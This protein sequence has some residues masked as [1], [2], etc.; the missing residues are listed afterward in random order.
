[1]PRD[2]PVY[3]W[4]FTYFP[5]DEGESLKDWLQYQWSSGAWKWLVGQAECAPDTGRIHLQGAGQLGTRKRLSGMK[6]LDDRVHWEHMN[7]SLA[8][9]RTYCT[10]DDTRVDGPW[11][12]GLPPT[13]GT[14]TTLQ[15]VCKLVI[16]GKTEAEIAQE[17]PDMY[18]RHYKG[19]R[20]LHQAIKLG[21]QKRDWAPELWV[22]VGPTRTGKTSFVAHNWPDAYW[23]S[24]TMG[25][26][27]DGYDGQETVVLDDCLGDYMTLTDFKRLIDRYPM[28]VQVKGGSVPMLAKRIVITS[29][30]MPEHWYS[31]DAAGAVVARVVE[32][33]QGRAVYCDHTGWR[34]LGDY[35]PWSPPE[36]Y[37][38]P[39]F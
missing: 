6:K 15:D 37:S 32:F 31:N 38:M 33:A 30:V 9:A 24:K 21:V 18:V 26:W 39:S 36:G 22:L 17:A 25:P 19:I 14:G 4:C 7:G 11:E 5:K 23:K 2:N 29:N 34:S 20:A 1:M 16:D 12:F 13:G 3:C 27:W 10:K 8:Q 35:Q 28:D